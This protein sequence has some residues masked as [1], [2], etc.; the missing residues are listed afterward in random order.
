MS[1]KA[2][3]VDNDFFF[4]EFLTEVLEKRGYEVFK[5]YDGK[6]CISKLDEMGP[7]DLLFVDLMMPKIDGRKVIEFTRNKFANTPFPII[8]VSGTIIEQLD[9]IDEIGADYYIAKGPMEQMEAHTGEFLDKI[10]KQPFP[11]ENDEAILEPGKIYPR[12]ATTE[13]I[14]AISFQRAVIES[15]GVGIIILDKDARIINTNSLALAM[16]NKGVEDVLN[17]PIRALFPSGEHTRLVDGLK[18][19]VHEHKL[20]K[21]TLSLTIDSREIRMNISLLKV[22]DRVDGW[23]IAMEDTKQ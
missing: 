19:L 6:E 17:R 15:I 10:E 11:P 21:I 20:R 8:A 3:V 9:E 18:K 23:I 5:A 2:L 12:Q 4:V 7:V 16:I 13:L 22:D 14:D 1:K